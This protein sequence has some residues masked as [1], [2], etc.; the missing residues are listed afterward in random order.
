MRKGRAGDCTLVS[1]SLLFCFS[2]LYLWSF[3]F[4]FLVFMKR[5][6][7][8]HFCA[9]YEGLHQFS[10]FFLLFG[11]FSFLAFFLASLLA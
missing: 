1:L 8:S 3:R 2:P 4:F 10:F 9:T 11:Y 6:F 5:R 7:F